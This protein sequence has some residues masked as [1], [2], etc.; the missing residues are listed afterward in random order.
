MQRLWLVALLL[1]GIGLAVGCGRGGDTVTPVSPTG[2]PATLPPTPLVQT[3]TIVIPTAP[4]AEEPTIPATPTPAVPPE[5][6]IPDTL[7]FAVYNEPPVAAQPAVVHDPIAPDLSNVIVPMALSEAQRARLAE[8]GFV[9]S[10]GMEKEFFTVYEQARYDNLPIFV[11]SDSLLHIYHLL[12]GKVLRTA[13]TDYFIPLLRQ[14]NRALLTEVELQYAQLR[15]GPWEE[16]ALRTVAFVG[17]G[18]RLLD[19]AVTLPAEALPLVEAEL[20]LIKAADGFVPSPIFPGLPYGEDYTQY[21][22]RGHYTKSE[23]LT[24][25]F[26]S[27]MWYGRMTFRLRGGDPEIGRQETRQALL[28]VQALRT[29]VLPTGVPALAAWEDLYSSTVFFVGRSDDLTAP[30]Y[31]AVMDA[32]YG[33]NPDLATLTD[34]AQLDA[35]IAAAAQLPPPRILGIVIDVTQD[36]EAES[37]GLRFMG[38]RFVPDAYIF[39]EL[40]FRNVG[41]ID[42]PRML[43]SGLDIMA[44]MGSQRAYEHLDALGET[45]Y[46]NYPAQMARMQDWLGGL[47][48][49]EWTETLYNGW[50]YSLRP[51][52]DVPGPGY[53]QFMQSPAWVDK[54]LNAAL[55]SW[56]ELKHDTILYAKQAYAELGGGGSEAPL[57]LPAQGYVEPVPQFYARLAALT[58]MTYNGLADRNLLNERDADS[59]VRLEQLARA[60]QVMAEKELRGEPLSEEEHHLIR[61]YGG[62]LENLTMAAADMEGDD[63]RPYLEE[64][65]QAAV[66]ADVA[67]AP[68]PGV[69]LEVGVGRINEIYVVVPLA[70]PDGRVQLQ[71]AKGGTFS[72]YEFPWPMGDRLTDEKWRGLLDAGQAPPPPGWIESFFST[73][74]GEAD[75]QRAVYQFQTGLSPAYWELTAEWYV[76][77]GDEVVAQIEAE[78]AALRDA[79]Q[80]IGRQWINTN[81]RSFDRQSPTTAVVAVRE[82]WQDVLYTGDSWGE[83]TEIGRRGPYTLDVTY[84]LTLQ[85]GGSWQVT[86]RVIA[87]EPP[88]WE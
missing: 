28:L 56:A 44:A 55:G 38:Q 81:Y 54:Q 35:F 50:L 57:P 40:I 64:Q 66:I 1:V 63:A 32:V 60:F 14:L 7:R 6:L 83:R 45:A 43:P 18:A 27:M 86:R 88:P 80:F 46:E 30:Q 37:K 39:R 10:P 4:P 9:V 25:Y 20:A 47:T 41:T 13:E 49:N 34:D 61:Y 53:P 2:A 73:M 22:A 62:E 82:T 42:N 84:T 71:V 76:L 48:V 70:L 21:I 69:V 15:G 23:A 65:P 8:L 36:V 12:F 24:A 26:K 33:P 72:Y 19:D 5:V 17:V 29:A 59:L 85:E 74:T 78:L 77:A 67:T 75:F 87:D 16:A 31:H 79:G 58:A 3:P 11:T 68:D 52:L 51:L